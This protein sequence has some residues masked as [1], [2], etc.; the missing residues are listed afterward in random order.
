M[1]PL[2]NF[3]C[4]CNDRRFKNV[5]VNDPSDVTD[6]ARYLSPTLSLSWV[7]ISPDLNTWYIANL[8]YP[9]W[10]ERDNDWTKNMEELRNR[11]YSAGIRYV[12][13]NDTINS[14]SY[15]QDLYICFIIFLYKW[16]LLFN[17]PQVIYNHS[18]NVFAHLIGEW[19][20]NAG[21]YSVLTC[22]RSRCHK[23]RTWWACLSKHLVRK[24]N[25][26]RTHGYIYIHCNSNTQT[27]RFSSKI[28][29]I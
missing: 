22:P 7:P 2:N 15:P 14:I 4:L 11:K 8:W 1:Q 28:F 17:C 13:N 12:P 23:W 20:Q 6:L 27:R 25:H 24:E 26:T 18:S 19:V 5:V 21:G 10:A 16:T 9:A 3:I 29:I